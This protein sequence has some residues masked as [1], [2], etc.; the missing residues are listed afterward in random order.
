MIFIPCV[1]WH[2]FLASVNE[3]NEEFSVTVPKLR[4]SYRAIDCEILL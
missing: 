4:S 1:V 2:T 3:I